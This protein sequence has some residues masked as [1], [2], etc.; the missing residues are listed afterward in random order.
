[1][2]ELLEFM[3]GVGEIMA[4]V[5]LL[6]LVVRCWRCFVVIFL[7]MAVVVLV[8]ANQISLHTVQLYIVG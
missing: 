1:M 8:P 5:V 3:C 4:V 2:V 7:S 6:L